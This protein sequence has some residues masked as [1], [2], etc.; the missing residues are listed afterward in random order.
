MGAMPATL[1]SVRT[2]RDRLDS[3]T[4][5]TLIAAASIAFSRLGYARTT[6]ADIT[7]RA[8]VSRATFYVYFASKDDV[9]RVLTERLRDEFLEAQEAQGADPDD[10]VAVA[11]ASVTR[12]V[13]VYAR[14]LAF[15]TVLE[16]QALTDE[17]LRTMWQGIRERLLKRMTRFVRHLVRDGVAHPVAP[18]EMVATAASGMAVRFAPL[19]AASP[20]DRP[21]IMGH[22]VRLYLQTL[23]V[24]PEPSAEEMS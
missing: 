15:I 11:A 13:D 16:H 2:G 14:N 10:Q 1:W 8:D 19:I 12:F 22:L 5:A 3:Q 7:E 23:G 21:L 20:A 24:E 17:D 9:F 6:V 4:R 18:P